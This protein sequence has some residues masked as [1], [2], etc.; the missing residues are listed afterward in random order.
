MTQI[1]S[2]GD[3]RIETEKLEGAGLE[4]EDDRCIFGHTKFEFW[5]AFQLGMFSVQDWNF[6]EVSTLVIYIWNLS[7]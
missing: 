5:M 6:G 3:W 4:K 2:L 1:S 7:A